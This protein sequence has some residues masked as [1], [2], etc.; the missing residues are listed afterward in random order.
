MVKGLIMNE[1]VEGLI[2]LGLTINGESPFETDQIDSFFET[3][4]LGTP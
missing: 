3:L 2:E 1:P 4:V